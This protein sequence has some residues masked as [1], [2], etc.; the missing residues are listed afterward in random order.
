MDT[1]LLHANRRITGGAFT[2]NIWIGYTGASFHMTNLAGGMF[3]ATEINEKF[4][5]ENSTN[6]T[7]TN[8][9]KRHGVIEQKDGTKKN[10]VLDKVKLVP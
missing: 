7:A 2:K 6:I 4:K 10:I 5:V 8:I 3:E 1:A 9:G